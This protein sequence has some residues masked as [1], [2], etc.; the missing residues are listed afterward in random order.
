MAISHR[1]C[2]SPH[3]ISQNR[4]PSDMPNAVLDN[5]TGKLM[6]CWHMMKNPKYRKLY[7]NS[8]AK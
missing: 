4:F 5:E 3:I 2:F 7:G 8:Y 1:R 6:K